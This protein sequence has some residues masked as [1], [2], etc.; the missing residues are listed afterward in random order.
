MRQADSVPFADCSLDIV[1]STGAMHHWKDPAAGLNEI[2]RIL[3]HG[4]YALIYDLVSDTPKSIMKTASQ[5]FGRLKIFVLWL[6]AFDEPFYSHKELHLL[7]C[8][9][10]FK[11]G[12]TQFVG[13]MCCLILRKQFSNSRNVGSIA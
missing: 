9:S 4:G 11:E 12:Q 2:Y 3:K 5:E 8:P 1:V 7:A 6:H 13:V 10:F